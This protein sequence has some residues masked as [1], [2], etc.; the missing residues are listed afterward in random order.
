LTDE[1]LSNRLLREL[2]ENANKAVK[3]LMPLFFP[4]SLGAVMLDLWG[5]DPMLPCHQLT[6]DKRHALISLMRAFTLG[7]KSVGPINAAIV[8]RGGIALKE[9][10]PK[11]MRSKRI[12]NVYFAG[13]MLDIDGY[14]GGFN[15]Q[16]AFSTGY[17]AGNFC[18]IL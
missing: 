9:I 15:L 14:T 3:N 11:T 12:P 17:A 7:V 13:E 8:T 4:R 2:G 16:I 10:D 5:V 1:Q 18:E 6:R